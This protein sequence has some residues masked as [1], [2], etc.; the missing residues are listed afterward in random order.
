MGANFN[1]NRVILG[2]RLAT[3]PEFK[4]TPNG[5]PVA[6]FTLAVNRAHTK[7]GTETDFLRCTAWRNTGE[8]INKFFR[9]GSPICIVGTVQT[10]TWTDKNGEKRYATDIVAEEATFVESKSESGGAPA[11]SYMP[12]SY[13]AAAPKFDAITED[14]EGDLPF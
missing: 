12:E 14:E 6:S 10:R 11:P 4:T 9:K 13:T 5:V 3:D 7:N 8:F 2:G 1:F